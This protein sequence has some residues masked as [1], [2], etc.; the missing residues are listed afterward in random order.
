MRD[1]ET[2][3]AAITAAETGHLVFSTL[4]TGDCVGAIDRMIGVFGA[5][6][7]L[8]LRQQLSMVLRGV[9]AQHLIRDDRSGGRTP[10][11][12]VLFINPAVANLIR[13]AK[14]SQIYSL[15]ELG[16][17]EGM[18]T[19]EFALADLIASGVLKEADA[20]HMARDQRALKA[21]LDRIRGFEITGK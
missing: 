7:Q 12:E 10:L 21:R 17:N 3:R 9:I 15:M 4:H 11:T 19:V 20:M 8:T 16:A 14:S 6:E 5:E 1:P 13:T 18:Q 2:I